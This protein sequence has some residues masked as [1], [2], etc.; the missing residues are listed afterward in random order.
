M[1]VT[2]SQLIAEVAVKGADSAKAQLLGVGSTSDSVGSKL[3]AGL[4]GA[5]LGAGVALIGM[6]AVATK[7][8]GDFKA[9]MTQLVTGAGESKSNLALVSNGILDL[10]TQT[11]MSTDQ[12]SKGMFMVE[13]ASFHGAAGLDVLKNAAIGAKVGSADLGVV[14]DATTTL[15]VDFAKSHLTASQAVNTLIATVANG[16]THMQDLATSLSQIMPTAS[17]AGISLTDTSAALATMT[18]EGVPAANAATYLRQT[19]LGLVA[20]SA[21]TVK[22]LKEVGL[23]SSDVAT[24]MKKSLPDALAM[25]TDAVGKKFPVGSAAYVNALKNISGGA[26]TMQGMLDLTGTHLATFQT[27]V[28]NI[29]NAVKKGGTSITG[30]ADI[31]GDFNQKVSQAKEVVETLGIKVGTALIPVVE[32]LMSNLLPVIVSFGDWLTSGN[33]LQN[34]INAVIGVL[35]TIIGTIATVVS[36]GA[37]IVGF[38]QHCQVAAAALLIPLGAL[39]GYFVFLGVTAVV[40]FI[41]AAP[42]MIAGFI[43][44]AAAAWTMAAGVIAATF[45]FILIGAAIG[46]VIAIIILL[47]THWGQVVSF[48]QS[49]WSAFSGWFMGALGT[50]GNFFKG[51][52]DGIVTFIQGVWAKITGGIK[53]AWN[54]VVSIIQGALNFVKDVITFDFN[55]IVGLFSWLYDHNYYFKDLVDTIRNVIQGVLDWL[56]S[57]WTNGVNF[58]VGLWNTLSNG[59]RSLWG[60]ITSSI[61]AAVNNVVNFIRAVWAADV[62]V[63]TALW[64]NLRSAASAVWN[65]IS[66]VVSSVVSNITSRLSSAWNIIRSDVQAAWNFVVSIFAGIWGR[67]S[68]P[69]N[70]L[71]NGIRGFFTGLIGQAA[72]WGSSLIQGFIGGITSMLGAVGN[73][74]AN[75]MNTVKGFLGFHS[76]SEKGEG[77]HI[78]EWGAGMLKGFSDGVKAAIPQLQATVNMALSAGTSSLRTPP[79][80]HVTF[81][82]MVQSQAPITVIVQPP[83][84]NLDG[85]RVSKK[86]MPHIANN[87]R[88]AVGTH[89]L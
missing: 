2:V 15:M 3:K 51:I 89:G 72:S 70:G 67:V 38:F 68:G 33:R 57:A 49:T 63:L 77:Q 20:P 39:G 80:N 25:I 83:D 42:A 60:N 76:P 64:N 34:G 85:Q 10:A 35:S 54:M 28:G 65:A 86:L 46:A 78:V 59:A 24:E 50:V 18:G 21:G 47:V 13:S 8:A 53:G 14:A 27:D 71:A 5:A 29:S 17:A 4:V 37:N 88:Y 31:Q 43:A 58:I 73:A 16:K 82:S 9:S 12:L 56:K 19:I 22:A 1:A 55:I 61:M 66:S 79:V 84:I 11:G 6:G 40:A 48:L 62:A 52:W 32:S 74:A 45:P 69:L 30:W 23:S 26:K 41:A 7:M 87:I 44:G 75:V 81:P 36:V